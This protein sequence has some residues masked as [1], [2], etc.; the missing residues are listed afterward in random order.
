MTGTWVD[1]DDRDRIRIN[2][3]ARFQRVRNVQR[4]P[5]VTLDIADPAVEHIEALAQEHLGGPCP[6]YGGRDQQRLVLT[7]EAGW[8]HSPQG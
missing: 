8:V 2:S 3:V 5:W 6:W 1:A 4:D 7:V